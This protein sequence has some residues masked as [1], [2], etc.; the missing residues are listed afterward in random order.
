[1]LGCPRPPPSFSPLSLPMQ[2]CLND[3]EDWELALHAALE[4]AALVLPIV[5]QPAL[6]GIAKNA[7][8]RRDNLLMGEGR[9]LERFWGVHC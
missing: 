7:P 8:T 5:S 1:M 3:G 4:G 2:T 6:D 9:Q